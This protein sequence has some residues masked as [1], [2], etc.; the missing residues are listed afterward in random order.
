MDFNINQI[1]SDIDKLMMNGRNSEMIRYW[2]SFVSKDGFENKQF[3]RYVEKVKDALRD[4]LPIFLPKKSCCHSVERML[5]VMLAI[6]HTPYE[7]SKTQKDV[8]GIY[9]F[10][11]N[12]IIYTD[13]LNFAEILSSDDYETKKLE[14]ALDVNRETHTAVECILYELR[15]AC[16]EFIRKRASINPNIDKSSYFATLPKTQIELLEI[17]QN[18]L[19][20]TSIDIERSIRSNFNEA[21]VN[22][23]KEEFVE[24][25]TEKVNNMAKELESNEQQIKTLKCTISDLTTKLSTVGNKCTDCQLDKKE[26]IDALIRENQKI[27]T[28]YGELLNKYHTIKRGS[29]DMDISIDNDFALPELDVTKRYLFIVG[30]EITFQSKITKAFPNALFTCKMQSLNQM[31]IECVIAITSCIDHSLYYG[32][33]SHC[34]SQNIPFIHCEHSNVELIKQ[35]LINTLY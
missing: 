13:K 27:K 35:L 34:K 10:M 21:L 18:T 19:N 31:D 32:M 16:K 6:Y 30:E 24:E 29:T 25:L 1:E 22:T 20:W 28:R 23:K 33:K 7:S 14:K 26:Y 11:H 3:E 15:Y 12:Y 17:V 4:F 8:D 2:H 5:L 9:Q